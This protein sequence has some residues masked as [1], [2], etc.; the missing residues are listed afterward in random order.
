MDAAQSCVATSAHLNLKV[1]LAKAAL[2]ERSHLGFILDDEYFHMFG[3]ESVESAKMSMSSAQATLE[4]MTVLSSSCHGGVTSTVSVWDACIS[5]G[6]APSWQ[7]YVCVTPH[8]A[9]PHTPYPPWRLY[10][11][12]LKPPPSRKHPEVPSSTER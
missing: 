4:N 9:S 1:L 12:R 10:E 5:H 11:A 7:R 3:R 2:K 6:P 8:H